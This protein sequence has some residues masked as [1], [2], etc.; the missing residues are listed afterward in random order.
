MKSLLFILYLSFSITF[1][2]TDSIKALFKEEPQL[3]K[4]I[5]IMPEIIGGLDLLQNE[6]QYP[7]EALINK[8][9]GKVYI[10]AFI[11]TLGNPLNAK[12]IKGIGYGCDEEARRL[13][14]QSKFTPAMTRGKKV[15]S[16]VSIPIVFKLPKQE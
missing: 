6:I 7:T 3:G 8:I 10:L 1:S 16:Q 11:D 2:Q 9:E 5:E 14:M 13:I 15:N 12:P 4:F